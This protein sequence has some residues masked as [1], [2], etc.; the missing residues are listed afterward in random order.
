MNQTEDEGSP[1]G[2]VQGLIGTGLDVYRTLNPAA[3]ATSGTVRPVTAPA[4]LAGV[5]W[6]V[7]AGGGVLALI[8]LLFALRK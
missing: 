8:A 2:F 4:Q 7:W 1:L 6:Y 3:P 5:P